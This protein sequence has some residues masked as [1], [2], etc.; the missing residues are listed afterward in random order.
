MPK[1]R[2]YVLF[3]HGGSAAEAPFESKEAAEL[4]AKRMA[5]K[6]NKSSAFA[7]ASVVDFGAEPHGQ[8]KDA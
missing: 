7:Y 5:E 4:E 6:F 2:A 8:G 1:W 3:S